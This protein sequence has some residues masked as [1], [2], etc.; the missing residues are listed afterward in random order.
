MSGNRNSGRKPKP[1]ELKLLEG[2]PGKRAIPNAPLARPMVSDKPPGWLEPAA[3]RIWRSTVK[4]LGSVPGWLRETD[5]SVLALYCDAYAEVQALRAY[6]T[7]QGRSYEAL[8]IHNDDATGKDVLET[9][10]KPRPEVMML[11]RARTI[12]RGLASDLG[13]SPTAR[14]RISLPDSDDPGDE[15]LDRVSS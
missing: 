11:A 1:V 7:A 9:T 15:L 3:R 6:I 14:A 10:W 13:L 2:N 8:Q 12:L 5:G 4:A